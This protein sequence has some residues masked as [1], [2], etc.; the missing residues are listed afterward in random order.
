MS[1]QQVLFTETW[2]TALVV[3]HLATGEAVQ[4]RVTMWFP[5]R[6]GY[7]SRWT[8]QAYVLYLVLIISTMYTPMFFIPVVKCFHW[9]V[10]FILWN[11]VRVLIA[12]VI[13]Y[14]A[15]FV[16]SAGRWEFWI[17]PNLTKRYYSFTERIQ[18]VY[19]WNQRMYFKAIAI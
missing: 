13:C 1:S 5:L 18:P 15:V 16:C 12:R 8:T 19:S 6:S 10:D 14:A 9:T 3:V 4:R 11:I 2:I 17:L 7:F